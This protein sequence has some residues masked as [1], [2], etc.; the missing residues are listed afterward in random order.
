[1]KK[2]IIA[3]L[4]ALI[5]A[6]SLLPMSVLA[7]DPAGS[8]AEDETPAGF[9]FSIVSGK[10]TVGLTTKKVGSKNTIYIPVSLMNKTAVLDFIIKS[11]DGKQFSAEYSEF[12]IDANEKESRTSKEAENGSVD[13]KGSY[14]EQYSLR[15]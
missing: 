5:M 3:L 15:Q 10:Q 8:G 1:M 6:V 12:D 11:S 13:I 7:A 9:S 4:L 14:A 2:K